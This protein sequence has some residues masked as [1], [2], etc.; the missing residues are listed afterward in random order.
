LFEIAGRAD[1]GRTGSVK[2]NAKKCK[3]ATKRKR[4]LRRDA[5]K[6]FGEFS[7]LGSL[8]LLRGKVKGKNDEHY[9][10]RHAEAIQQR[11]ENFSGDS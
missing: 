9:L 3:G 1:F 6:F 4:K 10:I 7:G 2:R 8:Q 11:A 5:E